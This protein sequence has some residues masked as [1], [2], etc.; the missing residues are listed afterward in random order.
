MNN[1]SMSLK[2]KIRNMA[3]QKNISAQVVLQMYMVE[4]FLERLLYSEY[5][6]NFILK[7]GVLVSA[8]VGFGNR[9]TMDMDTTLKNYPME[10]VY[11]TKAINDI[12]ELRLDDNTLFQMKKIDSIREDDIYGG[13]R[14][15]LE[16]TYDCSIVVPLQLDI[17][18][19]DAITPSEELIDYRLLFSEN[20]IRIWA[21]NVETILAE[22][23]ET[24]ITRGEFNTRPRDFYDLYVIS[25]MGKY[26]FEMFEEALR[27]TA[28]HRESDHIFDNMDTRIQEIC[29]SKL[30]NER[31][32]SYSREYEYANQINYNDIMRSLKILLKNFLSDKS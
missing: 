19:G 15:S 9:A 24:I 17:T 3:K 27:N 4:R 21:Y 5:K 7:G 31:W 26:S 18:T 20:T 6:D 12:C 13:F 8:I 28:I 10:K 2:A 25:R 11:L 14:A 1:N 16:A 30:L 23:I 22:K 29:N 32:I